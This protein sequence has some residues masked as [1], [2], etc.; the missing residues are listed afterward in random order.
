M[1]YASNSV[2][3]RL[4]TPVIIGWVFL[5]VIVLNSEK[6]NVEPYLGGMC[7]ALFLCGIVFFR[8]QPLVGM[9]GFISG[10]F[11]LSLMIQLPQYEP[12]FT[13]DVSTSEEQPA[14]S[15]WAFFIREA[16]LDASAV[17]PDFGG[18]LV[19]GLAI[20][21][22]S[23]VSEHLS[24]SM[25]AVSLTHITAVSGANC[26][27]VTASV[28]AISS[29]C[30]AGR[31]L[32]SV[33][34]VLAL[35]AFVILV[36]PQPS[37][38]RAAVMAVIV[39]FSF[40][41]GRPGSGVPL[42][43]ICVT[44]ILIWNPWW[45]TDFGFILSVSA[46]AG[47]LIF[48]GPITLRLSRYLPE[49]L[50]VLI[51]L[52]VAAQLMCQPFIILLTPQLPTYG[53]LANVIAAPAAPLATILGLLACLLVLWV[54]LLALVLLWFAWL[55]AEWIAHTSLVLSSFPQAQLPWLEGIGGSFL[56]ALLSCSV[57][58]ALLSP[59]QFVQRVISV[60]L[61]TSAL[62]WFISG[63]LSAL[64]FS[65]SLPQAWNIAACDVGQGDAI[66]LRS[67]DK[68]ALID[69]GRHPEKMTRCLEQLHIDRI[70]L[71][72]LT[73]FDKDHVGGLDAVIGKVDRA[74]VGKP[75]NA[76]DQ[77]LLTDLKRAGASLERG[78]Q[79]LAGELGNARW[80]VLW[81]DGQHPSMEMGN[82]GSV[83]LLVIFP[84]F[85]SLFLGDLGKESQLALMNTV[86]LPEIHVVK[87]AHHGSADQSISLYERLS[88]SIGIYSVGSENEYGHPRQEALDMLSNI[89]AVTPRTDSDG[90][91]LISSTA[92]GLSVWTEH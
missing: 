25:K 13:W 87:V 54:P 20:G 32:R 49:W 19:P 29:L 38:V 22:T 88:P 12:S 40:M 6:V 59:S 11:V 36:T 51:A 10:A 76:E 90:L 72:V 82:P 1:K 2:D 9:S 67:E 27:I 77:S 79:G 57:L 43:S 92:S 15:A 34:A 53:V 84:E 63:A 58:I 50:A 46:T 62:V 70:D 4:A 74:V 64:L 35:I 7:I 69:V 68:I 55:P 66:V 45:S 75:E 52:P 78:T 16:F 47:L 37:V 42:L 60:V 5:V 86:N 26:V 65:A 31:K 8:L 89:G 80:L 3:L 56:A 39:I 17:L 71:L 33:L 73:H 85:N 81:P 21:D 18:Q 24:E 48:S 61:I 91:I 83:T 28:M 41:S 44:L 23:R 30:G 14:W